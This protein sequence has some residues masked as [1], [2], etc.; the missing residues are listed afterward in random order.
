MD[1]VVQQNAGNAEESAS[2]SAEM[3]A[4]SQRMKGLVSELKALV[5]GSTAGGAANENAKIRNMRKK[6]EGAPVVS[7]KGNGTARLSHPES[8]TPLPSEVIP[9]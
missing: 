2:A 7:G 4:Q 3:N 9:F 1:A 6:A 8:E 5:N